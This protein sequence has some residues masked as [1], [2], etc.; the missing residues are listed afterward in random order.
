MWLQ[1]YTQE[2]IARAVHVGQP[3]VSRWIGERFKLTPGRA[4]L[5]IPA[6]PEAGVRCPQNG[7][8]PVL[9]DEQISAVWNRQ[10]DWTS[11]A[12]SDALSEAYGVSYSPKYCCGLLARLRS[13]NQTTRYM[14]A[15]SAPAAEQIA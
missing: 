12:F 1:G 13:G 10:K 4:R 2:A 5:T 14:A 3:A 9:T 8:P 11:R 7:R 15:R 6:A